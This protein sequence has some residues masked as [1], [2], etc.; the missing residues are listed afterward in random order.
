M[1]CFF[2]FHNYTKWKDLETGK[3]TNYGV[4]VGR[5]LRQT[6]TCTLCGKT[7][8]RTEQDC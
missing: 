3:L 7:S 8:M 4:T 5:Y 6:R 2:G 1:R